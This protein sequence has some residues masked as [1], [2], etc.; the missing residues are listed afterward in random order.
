MIHTS[1]LIAILF[2]ALTT[3]QTHILGYVLLKNRSLTNKQRQIMEV[4]PGCVLI[5]VIAPYFV[6]DHPAD[7]IVMAIT[8]F[9][10]SRFS[11]LPTVVISML[12]AAV[13]RQILI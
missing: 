1:T 9:A 4:V 6:K 2:I 8:L 13:L 7:L 10:A 12:S 5:S 11:L 3:Y